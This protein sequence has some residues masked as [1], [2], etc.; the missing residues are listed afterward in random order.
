[1]IVDTVHGRIDRVMKREDVHRAVLAQAER[2]SAVHDA[3]TCSYID[4]QR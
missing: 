2:S 1:M 4:A 3:R